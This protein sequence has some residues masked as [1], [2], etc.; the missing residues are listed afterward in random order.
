MLF[1]VEKTVK[2]KKLFEPNQFKNKNRIK[3][4][5]KNKNEYPKASFFCLGFFNFKKR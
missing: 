3:N 1:D 5:I 4:M 2:N